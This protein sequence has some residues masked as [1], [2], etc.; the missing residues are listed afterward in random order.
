M[1][2]LEEYY[3]YGLIEILATTTLGAEL[4]GQHRVAKS[5]AYRLIGGTSILSIDSITNAMPGAPVHLR[6]PHAEILGAILKT[7]RAYVSPNVNTT[8]DARHILQAWQNHVDYFV[9][10]E[11]KLIEATPL[12]SDTGVD[13]AICSD[14]ECLTRI[15]QRFE[16]LHQTSDIH[17]L[18]EIRRRAHPIGLGSENCFNFLLN[19]FTAAILQ[20]DI[21][22][23]HLQLA[24]N[25]FDEEGTLQLEIRSGQKNNF[26][27][28]LGSVRGFGAGPIRV[29][30]DS[31]SSVGIYL[32]DRCIL[33][34]QL[35]SSGVVQ[36]HFAS[37]YNS[38]GQISL[39]IDRDEFEACG[40]V[41]LNTRFN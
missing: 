14:V 22:D 4:K 17:R 6:E 29:G 19:D 25:I 38:A 34:G 24:S 12:L 1:N 10:E 16:R 39:R 26:V 33:S 31:W 8:R 18:A 27:G 37:L 20:L 11:R 21:V 3:K 13:I 30:T 15:E 35:L 41:M 7:K 2:R 23:G 5:K 36:F 40:M 9:T 28:P 32:A